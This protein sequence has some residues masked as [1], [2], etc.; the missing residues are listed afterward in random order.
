M[1]PQPVQSLLA[2]PNLTVHPST[3]SVPITVLPYNGPLLCGFDVSIKGLN[4]IRL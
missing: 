4:R 1:G 3:T 2:V